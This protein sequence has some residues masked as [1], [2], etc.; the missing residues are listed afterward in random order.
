MIMIVGSR[1]TRRCF[2]LGSSQAFEGSLCM[3]TGTDSRH[4]FCSCSVFAVMFYLVKT[5]SLKE[6]WCL[7][8]YVCGQGRSSFLGACAKFRKANI[9]LVMSVRPSVCMEQLRSL[10]TDFDDI[11]YLS[12]FFSFEN[13]SRKCQFYLKSD[14]NGYFVWRRFHIYDNIS[15]NSSYSETFFG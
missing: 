8:V 13:L 9:S 15:L 4:V 10:W 3:T 11:W 6:Q 2:K 5:S 12:V 14:I 7:C 1:R